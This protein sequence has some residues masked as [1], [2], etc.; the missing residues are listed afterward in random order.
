MI[1]LTITSNT[2]KKKINK[3][4]Q[5]K[6]RQFLSTYTFRLNSKQ[7]VDFHLLLNFMVFSLHAGDISPCLHTEAISILVS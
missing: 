4:N 3:K 1:I 2:K 6:W 5:Q 7:S